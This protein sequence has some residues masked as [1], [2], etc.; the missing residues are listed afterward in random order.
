M[1]C[2][3]PWRPERAEQPRAPPPQLFHLIPRYF[4]NV[5]SRPLWYTVD[6]S[7]VLILGGIPEEKSILL[8]DTSFKD[9]FLVEVSAAGQTR[10]WGLWKGLGLSP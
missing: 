2:R 5:P 9:F 7:P 4:V 1:R 3:S 10:G 8:T 6:Q